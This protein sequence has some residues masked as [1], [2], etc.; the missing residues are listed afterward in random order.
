MFLMQQV[1]VNDAFFAEAVSV[2][3]AHLRSYGLEKVGAD[4]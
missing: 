2:E 1:E 3:W 4:P